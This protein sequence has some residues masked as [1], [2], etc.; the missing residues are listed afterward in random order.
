MAFN[1]IGSDESLVIREGADIKLDIALED[2]NGPLD[3][4]GYSATMRFGADYDTAAEL[5]LTVGSGL[6]INASEGIIT[7]EL[8]NVQ[9]AAFTFSQGRYDLEIVDG[10]GKIDPVLY[11]K[12]TII[13]KVPN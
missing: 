4:T 12:V 1:L 10:S 11:G 9:T 5:T 7:F 2:E 3:L 13:Q 6:T 8:T